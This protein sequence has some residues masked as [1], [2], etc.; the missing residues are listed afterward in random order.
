MPRARAD[1]TDAP[2]LSYNAPV[3]TDEAIPDGQRHPRHNATSPAPDAHPRRASI[4]PLT[5][6][7][8]S[9]YLR[10]LEQL[11]EDGRATVSSQQLANAL[12]LTAAQVRK[13][14]GYFGQ[15]GRRGVGYHVDDLVQRL[16][17]IFGTD[18]VWNVAVVGVGSLGRALL[19]YKGFL[20]K[21]F[22]L[23]A[24]FDSAPAKI[25]RTFGGVTVRAM[26]HLPSSVKRQRLRL[27]I[28]AVPVEAAQQVTDAI[29][30]AGIK[31]ILNFV[32]ATL[33]VSDDVAV[34]PVD[35]AVQL[36]QLS[37]LVNAPGRDRRAR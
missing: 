37:Y 36:E 2:G 11:A 23:A 4:S 29:C 24:A 31:A 35:L 1:L 30:D 21:G 16:R 7:R 8:L 12:D 15:F 34:I 18:K 6:K 20:K 22:R 28:L 14:L 3:M 9:L 19:G 33:N 26:A 17:G 5:V 10:C 13:D 32:P 25:G 27:A